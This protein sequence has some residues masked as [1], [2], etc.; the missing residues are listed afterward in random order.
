MVEGVAAKRS[1]DR[2]HSTLSLMSTDSLLQTIVSKLKAV[3]SLLLES[4]FAC[5]RRVFAPLRNLGFGLKEVEAAAGRLFVFIR[6][7]DKLAILLELTLRDGARMEFVEVSPQ[8]LL[9]PPEGLLKELHGLPRYSL[10]R[11]LRDRSPPALDTLE[12]LRGGNIANRLLVEELYRILTCH[13][14]DL[15]AARKT[16]KDIIRNASACS[17]PSR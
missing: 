7:K 12:H 1:P 4:D 15:L 13:F 17:T 14:G 10:E 8:I 3:V 16:L 2:N 5:A 11:I 6:A 9:L